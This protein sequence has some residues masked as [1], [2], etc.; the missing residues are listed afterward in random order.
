[1]SINA[2]EIVLSLAVF[3]ALFVAQ[4]PLKHIIR[5]LKKSQPLDEHDV[6]RL[7]SLLLFGVSGYAVLSRSHEALLWILAP[8][9]VTA[10]LGLWLNHRRASMFLQSLAGFAALTLAGPAIVL[11][12]DA[13]LDVQQIS[14]AGSLW[15]ELTLFFWASAM[16]VNI[17]IDPSSTR[18]TSIGLGIFL[19]CSLV[20]L[21]LGFFSLAS[22]VALTVVVLRFTLVMSQFER[23]RKLSLK[24]IGMIEAI[25]ALKM[26]GLYL[27][28]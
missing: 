1:V 8:G 4:E 6:S 16:T 14:R 26:V 11:M 24:K 27:W 10:L 19:V 12:G 18:A 25:A 13:S 5:G 7:F 15:A 3:A 22:F 20:G 9:G 28:L 2:T 21:N 23:Y 17:R